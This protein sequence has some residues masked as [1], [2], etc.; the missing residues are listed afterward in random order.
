MAQLFEIENE[1]ISKI[2]LIFDTGPFMQQ[3]T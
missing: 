3:Q 2:V 1:K